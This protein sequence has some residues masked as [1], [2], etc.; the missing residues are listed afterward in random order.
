MDIR[1]CVI[2]IIQNN[3]LFRNF[4]IKIFNKIQP[5]DNILNIDNIHFKSNF[6]NIHGKAN[7]LR[8]VGESFLQRCQIYINGEGNIIDINAKTEIYGNNSQTFHVDG[9]NNQ[10][11]IGKNCIIRNT[12]FF[13]QE[14]NNLI[15]L[16]DDISVFGAE[17][18][19]E[20]N[21]NCLKIGKGTTFHGRNGYP[22]HI[23]LDEGSCIVID[24][25]C[26]FSNGIQ[27][28]STDSHSIIDM[29]GKRINYA[30]DI[31][32]GKHSWVGLGCI[33]LKGTNIAPHT[34]V[35][36]GSICTSKFFQENCIVAGNPAKIVKQNID[37]DRK[38]V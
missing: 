4:A 15:E 34:V 6:I 33:L 11:L 24:E 25:D 22:V 28:R 35:A 19:I 32:I 30:E 12:T 20:Q 26:M 10:I 23:A 8:C 36:A 2:N 18:H 37:W 13:I 7:C 17:F 21:S 14:S 3:L 31:Y 29:N 16:E 5:G 38:F 9:D 1:S 27:V